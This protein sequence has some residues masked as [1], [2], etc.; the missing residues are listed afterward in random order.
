MSV[1]LEKSR[2]SDDTCGTIRDRHVR[3]DDTR[4]EENWQ[5]VAISHQLNI[6]HSWPRFSAL[7]WIVSSMFVLY[8]VGLLVVHAVQ[9][10][11]HLGNR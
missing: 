1:E 4:R 9:R 7:V 8:K 6:Y 10:K 3:Q 2:Q 11:L 5:W